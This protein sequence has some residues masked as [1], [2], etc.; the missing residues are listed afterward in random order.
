MLK[1]NKNKTILFITL[2]IILI[3]LVSL[4]LL[5]RN[6]P[7]TIVNGYTHFGRTSYNQLKYPMIGEEIAVIQTNMGDIKIRLF[8]EVAPNTIENFK[9]LA[10]EGFYDGLRFDRIEADFLIQMRIIEEHLPEKSIRDNHLEI[11]IHEDYRHF[12]GSVGLAKNSEGKGG[13]SFYII[14]NEGIEPDYLDMVSMVGEEVGY[15]PKVIK[16]YKAFG[17]IP[18][19]DYNYTI[20]GQVF[21]GMDTVFEINKLPIVRDS[22]TGLSVPLE[23]VIIETI[24]VIPYEGNR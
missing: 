3:L 18:R 7:G 19:L 11:E 23:P 14:C 16:A 17:G 12:T 21:Y 5:L 22:E 8:P 10:T 4:F 24:K 1:F 2:I 13:N 15:P 6:R 20:F 9:K